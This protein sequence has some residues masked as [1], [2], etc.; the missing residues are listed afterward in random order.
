MSLFRYGCPLMLFIEF[1]LPTNAFIYEIG[2][3]VVAENEFDSLM[4]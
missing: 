1:R 2:F 4:F 3:V